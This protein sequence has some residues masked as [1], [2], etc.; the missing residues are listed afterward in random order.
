MTTLKRILLNASIGIL[1]LS[2]ASNDITTRQIIT[3]DYLE[4]GTNLKEFIQRHGPPFSVQA[5]KDSVSLVHYSMLGKMSNAGFVPIVNLVASGNTYAIKRYVLKFSNE[6]K[7]IEIIDANQVRGFASV[8][9]MAPNEGFSGKG[10]VRSEESYREV[11]R[12]LAEKNIFFDQELWKVQN[13][14]NNY[15]QKFR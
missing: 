4:A 2:C 12:F 11:G 6:G 3:L 7:F 9:Q 8:Y 15:F 5:N 10:G 1:I 14:A 13:I